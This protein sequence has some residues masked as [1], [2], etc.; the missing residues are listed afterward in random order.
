MKLTIKPN[1]VPYNISVPNNMGMVRYVL[2]IAVII[3]HYNEL[4][5]ANIY[6]PVTSYVAVGGFFSLSGFLI[7][8]SFLKKP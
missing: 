4:V 3:A 2:A 1:T 5:G 7:Y 6:F 8:G